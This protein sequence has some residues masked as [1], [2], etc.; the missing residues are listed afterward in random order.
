MLNFTVNPTLEYIYDWYLH[1]IAFIVFPLNLVTFYL[2]CK[3]TSKHSQTYRN[4]VL[5]IQVIQ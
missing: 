2:I 5:H 3:K 1:G 4:Y